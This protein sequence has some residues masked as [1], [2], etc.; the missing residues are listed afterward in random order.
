MKKTLN[1]EVLVLNKSWIGIRIRT[2][3]QSLVLVWR[4]RAFIVDVDDYNVYDWDE[5]ANQTVDKDKD[6]YI[7]TTHG[8]IKKPEVIVLSHYNK[9]P[10]HELRLT[11]KNILLRDEYTC[12]YTGERLTKSQI[13]IDHVIPKSKGGKNTWDNL[14]VS[15]KDINRLKA[16][17]TLEEAGLT[18]IRKPTKPIANIPLIH[19]IKNV[20]DSWR[21]FIK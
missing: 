9:I 20:P 8:C 12:Q 17:K 10:K 13:D 3:Q 5:W 14:V 2:V 18:L 6:F 16:D 7:A 1:H 15:S 4:K 19:N 21:K 11:K